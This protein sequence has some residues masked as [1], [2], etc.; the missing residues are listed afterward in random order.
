MPVDFAFRCT[1]SLFQDTNNAIY[2]SRVNYTAA[3]YD[4]V[5]MGAEKKDGPL[6]MDTNDPAL[7]K[8]AYQT[9][10]TA[11]VAAN[12]TTGW[13]FEIPL[14]ALGGAAIGSDFKMMVAYIDDFKSFNADVLPTIVGQTAVLGIDPNFTAI[15]GN[16]FYTYRVG[17]GVLGSR[18]AM[19]DALAATTYPNPLTNASQLSYTVASGT[20]PVSVDVY[21]ALGQRVLPLLNADQVAG[22]HNTALAPLQKLAASSYLVRLRV[23]PQLTSRRVVVE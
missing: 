21:N 18:A 11:S 15:A 3:S 20:Q 4:E 23:G 19:A 17:S 2:L 16:Q 8:T 1:T 10:T 14:P 5:G 22:P 12:T 6:T 7:A 13:E 9:S